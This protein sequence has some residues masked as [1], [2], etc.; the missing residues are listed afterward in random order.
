MCV[1][2][3]ITNIIALHYYREVKTRSHE[4]PQLAHGFQLAPVMSRMR[5]FSC[6]E[7]QSGDYE[8]FQS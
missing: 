8:H 4:G 2:V 5:T 7:P 3:Y 1:Y 6:A